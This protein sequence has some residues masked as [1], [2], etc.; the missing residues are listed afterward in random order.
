MRQSGGAFSLSASLIA[1]FCF[2][3]H[4][5]IWTRVPTMKR[6]EKSCFSCSTSGTTCTHV[7]KRAHV[8]PLDLGKAVVEPRG[9]EPVTYRGCTAPV[10]AAPAR[11]ASSHM[12]AWFHMLHTAPCA[13]SSTH[14]LCGSG[15]HRP[16][17]DSSA[18]FF[19]GPGASEHVSMLAC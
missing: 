4:L 3:A 19:P 1:D 13:Q 14:V 10:I 15:R 18:A 16:Q 2:T 11:R 7:K 6:L 17:Q 8:S 9:N 5:S 12:H